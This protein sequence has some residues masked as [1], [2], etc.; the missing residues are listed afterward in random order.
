MSTEHN[1]E[2]FTFTPE[3]RDTDLF[4]ETV[5]ALRYLENSY[6]A[7]RVEKSWPEVILEYQYKK[8]KSE[9]IRAY[10]K[11]RTETTTNKEIDTLKS[12][13]LVVGRSSCDES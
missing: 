13:H 2:R 11:R 10:M 4:R 6:Q 9:I 7:R 3:E 12:G 8:Q 5:K 1:V